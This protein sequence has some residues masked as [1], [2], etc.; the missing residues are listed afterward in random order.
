MAC[1]G[2]LHAQ[3]TPPSTGAGVVADPSNIAHMALVPITI[4]VNVREANGL[5]LEEHAFVKLSSP[6]RKYNQTLA[7]EDNSS[8]IF[9]DVVRGDYEIEVSSAGYKTAIEHVNFPGG[10]S[11]SPVFIYLH[12]E[13]ENA[14]SAKPPASMA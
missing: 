13:S 5:L 1:A 6:A 12:S 3:R 9:K 10:T 8:A 7:R 11:V 4:T 2:S 14:V